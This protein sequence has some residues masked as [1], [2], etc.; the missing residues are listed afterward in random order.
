MPPTSSRRRRTTR[1]ARSLSRG[2]RGSPSPLR[3]SGKPARHWV[4]VKRPPAAGI[5]FAVTVWCPIDS[6]THQER[7]TLYLTTTK[8]DPALLLEQ[9][10]EAVVESS[11]MMMSSPEKTSPIQTPTSADKEV[12]FA[13][14][15]LPF[16]EDGSL[17]LAA[18][19]PVAF[20][21]PRIEEPD[22]SLPPGGS[23]APFWSP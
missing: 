11:R 18:I 4:S 20:K 10:Q 23:S 7:E 1:S 3:R 14:D 16:E 5:G 21:R 17:A 2:P 12:T 22:V 15:D 9:Q 13:F 19:P 8:Q 6:L